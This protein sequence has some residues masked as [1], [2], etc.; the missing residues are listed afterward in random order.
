M[1]FFKIKPVLSVL[2]AFIII[3]F[4]SCS[5]PQE[6]KNEHQI[7]GVQQFQEQLSKESKPQLIDVRTSS[8]Y[9]NGSI[10]GAVNYDFLDGTFQ[11]QLTSLDKNKT[12]FVFCAKG[13]RS[14]KASELLKKNGFQSIV[15]LEGGYSAWIKK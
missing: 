10:E 5:N 13:G 12:V 2:F 8:E 7:L 9:A 1:E 14:G 4:S 11:K 15:D 6:K 3:S